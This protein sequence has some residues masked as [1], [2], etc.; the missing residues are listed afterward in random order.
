MRAS[1]QGQNV[2]MLGNGIAKLHTP[3]LVVDP[4]KK[5]QKPRTARKP[6]SP[7]PRPKTSQQ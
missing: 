5:A 4:P 1:F 6:V 3:P 7:K 2:L